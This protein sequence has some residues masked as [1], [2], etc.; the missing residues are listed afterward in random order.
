[1]FIKKNH[2]LYFRVLA[3]IFVIVGLMVHL[4]VFYGT[5]RPSQ[6]MYYTLQSNVL[7]AILFFFLIYSD[8]KTLKNGSTEKTKDLI[9]RF[10]IICV[11]DLLLTLLVYWILLAPKDFARG[12]NLFRFVNLAVHFITPMLCVVD[13]FIFAERS[14]VKYKDVYYSLIFPLSYVIYSSIAGFC[15]YTYGN[16]RDGS[17]KHYPYFFMDY[18]RTGSLSILYIIM[19]S[20]ILILIGHAVYYSGKRIKTLVE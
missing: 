4:H 18:D 16:A 15:G 19:V 20:I 3:L 2:S 14:R 5:F 11:I 6:L 9:N 7:A 17:P 1:M 12:D 13:Y 10:E 8:I